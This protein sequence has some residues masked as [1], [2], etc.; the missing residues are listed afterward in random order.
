MKSKTKV[1]EI[2]RHKTNPYLAETIFLAKKNNLEI[3]SLIAVPSRRRVEVNLDRLNEAKTTE[4]IIPGK[5]L[6]SGNISK[7]ITIY[8]L[9]FSEQAK[10]KLKKAGCTCILL[11]DAFK[12]NTRLKG[13]I[14]K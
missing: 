12:K 2:M 10:E 3:A 5:V 9:N 11:L 6:G 1:N 4:I 14:I 13:E 8:A 7:K